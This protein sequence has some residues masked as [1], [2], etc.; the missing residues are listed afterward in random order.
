MRH[1]EQLEHKLRSWDMYW[2]SHDS[3]V[4]CAP[5][6]CKKR[7]DFV[8][9]TKEWV[10][11]LECDEDHHRYY[12]L[13]CEVARI[14]VLK[15][16]LKLP[17]L[18]IRFNPDK[19]DYDTL[20]RVLRDN[21][22]TKALNLAHNEFGVHIMYLGYPEARVRDLNTHAEDTCGMPFPTTEMYDRVDHVDHVNR[23]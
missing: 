8:F 17:M 1:E 11:V 14:G 10:V 2:S 19:A 23:A 20:E 5:K 22:S 13:S 18:L 15:D 6:G 7:P 4:P 12:E 3:A 16:Q 21:L 9:C